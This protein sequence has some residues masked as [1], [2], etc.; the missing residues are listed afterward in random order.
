[1]YTKTVTWLGQISVTFS[2][3]FNVSSKSPTN[4]SNRSFM[5]IKSSGSGKDLLS[6]EVS[7]ASLVVHA[8]IR[9]SFSDMQ[10]D[11]PLEMHS[12]SEKN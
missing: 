5:E 8:S 2:V 12:I 4:S 11:C 1:M 6:L 7:L 9:Q 10:S 3:V